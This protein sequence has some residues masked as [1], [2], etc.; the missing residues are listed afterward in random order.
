[1]A[2]TLGSLEPL[3][4]DFGTLSGQQSEQCQGRKRFQVKRLLGMPM[5][6]CQSRGGFIGSVR[7]SWTLADR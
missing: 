6:R 5:I 3:A 2:I 7:P 4:T 1:M